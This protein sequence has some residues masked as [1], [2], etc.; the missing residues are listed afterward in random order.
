MYMSSFIRKIRNKIA[1]LLLD[2]RIYTINI[3]Q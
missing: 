3:L 1:D 2:E